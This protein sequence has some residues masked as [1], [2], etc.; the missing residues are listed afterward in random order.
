MQ[1]SD[2]PKFIEDKARKRASGEMVPTAEDI[3]KKIYDK[4][5]TLLSSCVDWANINEVRAEGFNFGQ[6]CHL[7]ANLRFKIP[8]NRFSSRPQ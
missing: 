3:S 5:I 2:R 7:V 8:E 4:R 1:Y 6:K